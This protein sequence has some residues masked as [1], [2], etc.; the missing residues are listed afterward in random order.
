ML[1]RTGALVISFFAAAFRANQTILAGSSSLLTRGPILPA[2][3]SLRLRRGSPTK[4]RVSRDRYGLGAAD[5]SELAYDDRDLVA[6][7]LL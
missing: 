6:N 3:G 1:L 4:P 7:G 5:C 2:A